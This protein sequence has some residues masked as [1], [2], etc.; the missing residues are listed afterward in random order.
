MCASPETFQVV[1]ATRVAY[2]SHEHEDLVESRGQH[3]KHICRYPDKLY[4]CL[5]RWTSFCKNC[6]SFKDVNT[7][8]GICELGCYK[9][10]MLIKSAILQKI[11][12][13]HAQC[14]VNHN[15]FSNHPILLRPWS[16]KFWPKAA[17]NLHTYLT[18]LGPE[19]V[20]YSLTNFK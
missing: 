12:L 11:W 18:H 14:D 3:W 8:W 20:S 15:R 17:E 10:R 19:Y 4:D 2:E 1:S 7:S 6:Q 5:T 16:D 9:L 13:H